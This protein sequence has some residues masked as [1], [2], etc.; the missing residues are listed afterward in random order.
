MTHVG[1]FDD[2]VTDE[3]GAKRP[4]GFY[5]PSTTKTSGSMALILIP[6]G[7]KPRDFFLEGSFQE[8]LER[9]ATVGY[10]A[11]AP[12]GWDKEDPGF[13]I[14]ATVKVLGEMKSSEFFP[15]KSSAVYGGSSCDNTEQ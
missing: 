6:G 1:W 10:F 3:K 8:T 11:S 9:Y 14:D 7:K 15:S 4:F 12:D 2:A 5:I 13:E